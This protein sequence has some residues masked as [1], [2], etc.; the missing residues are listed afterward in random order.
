MWNSNLIV[1]DTSIQHAYQGKPLQAAKR[2]FWKVLVRD[3]KNNP[4]ISKINSWQMG[5]LQAS[6][7]LGAKWIAYEALPDSSK[8]APLVHLNGKKR[9]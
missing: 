4:A 2:Y 1:S 8:I 9:E 6:D 5:L 3:N 7:W